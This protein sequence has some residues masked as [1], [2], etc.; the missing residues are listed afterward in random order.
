[1]NGPSRFL[2]ACVIGVAVW[3]SVPRAQVEIDRIVSRVGGRA[4][5]ASDIGRARGLKLV[6]D[7]SS[8][9]AVRRGIENRWLILNELARAAPLAPAS[10]ADLAARRA[11]WH[12]ALGEDPAGRLRQAGMSEADLGT[13][14]RDDLRIR[15]YLDRQF[16]RLAEGE[17]QRATTEWVGRLRQRADLTP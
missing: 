3:G 16:G 14:L 5:T 11:E 6:D 4:I 17:R 9:E 12:A 8:D 1:M 10:D 13:W 7:T 15:A 2:M